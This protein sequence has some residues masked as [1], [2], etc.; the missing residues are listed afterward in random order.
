MKLI[1]S[2]NISLL[3]ST[4]RFYIHGCIFFRSVTKTYTYHDHRTGLLCK[5]LEL[6]VSP[7]PATY[8]IIN[9]SVAGEWLDIFFRPHNF[10][11]CPAISCLPAWNPLTL[12]ANLQATCTRI[13]IPTFY[14][15]SSGSVFL[16]GRESRRK[17]STH[18]ATA[19]RKKERKLPLS[20]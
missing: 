7:Y 12:P 17:K 5:R 16:R 15:C 2:E 14:H 1:F 9:T 3:A 18:S 4:L 13:I 6:K 11:V 8:L 20:A 10:F 19:P